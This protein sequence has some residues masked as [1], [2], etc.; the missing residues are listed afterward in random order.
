M[1]S[2]GYE[3]P[4]IEFR[5]KISACNCSI[6]NKSLVLRKTSKSFHVMMLVFLGLL[7]RMRNNNYY[8]GYVCVLFWIGN[9]SQRHSN[10]SSNIWKVFCVAEWITKIFQIISCMNRLGK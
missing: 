1:A 10:L 5:A 2:K 7:I 9:Q 8:I 3:L 4:N 6:F